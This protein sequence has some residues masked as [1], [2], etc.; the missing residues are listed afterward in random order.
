MRIFERVNEVYIR[1]GRHGQREVLHRLR[2]HLIQKGAELEIDRLGRPHQLDIAVVRRQQLQQ[3]HVGVIADA[4]GQGMWTLT[5]G[6]LAPFGGVPGGEFAIVNR[7]LGGSA[8]ADQQEVWLA[9]RDLS[10]R[11]G[12]RALQV[13]ASAN[14]AVA[15][16]GQGL[17][18]VGR[19]G[20]TRL[21]R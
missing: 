19:A 13:R 21:R 12:E 10:E 4:E 18:D 6:S 1:R 15:D 17:L 2:T 5:C 9:W 20:W 11:R 7:P 3:R 16:E 14:P 8:V